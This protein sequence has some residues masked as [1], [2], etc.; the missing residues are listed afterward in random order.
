VNGFFGLAALGIYRSMFDLVSKVW[1]FSNT[2]GIVLYPRFIQLMRRDD[3]RGRLRT[4][5]PTV[6]VAS[7][8]SYCAL[9]LA[10]GLAGPLVLSLLHMSET[11]A[12]QLFALLLL[13]VLWN[14]HSVFSIELMQAGGQFR[15]VG[16][17]SAISFV[18]MTLAF[19]ALARYAPREAIGWAWLISQF[20]AAC[21]TD[22]RALRSLGGRLPLRELARTR[23][24][25]AALASIAAG[26]LV[27][28]PVAVLVLAAIAALMLLA[29]DTPVLFEGVR[30]L[31][32]GTT[33]TSEA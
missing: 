28:V 29:V 5:L 2:A 23:V 14:A 13:G 15:A 3:S 11:S 33:V 17:A 8:V 7:W 26:W 4:L 25:A 21:F 32:R 6:Q 31:L 10:G 12:P 30:A 22:V 20:I 19:L 9:G 16:E 24:P 18:V 1:F 27:G